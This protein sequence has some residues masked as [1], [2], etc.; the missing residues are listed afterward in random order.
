[1]DEKK[2][3]LVSLIANHAFGADSSIRETKI[4]SLIRHL[5][6]M[7]AENDYKKL[8]KTGKVPYSSPKQKENNYE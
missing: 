1:M 8:Q 6:R 7:A 4:Q 2:K 3:I 5:A